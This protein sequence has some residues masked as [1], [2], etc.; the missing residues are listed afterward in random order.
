MRKVM[1]P[2]DVAHAWANQHQDEARNSGGSFYFNGS[3]IYSYG[4]HFPI[5]K[6]VTNEQGQSA[7]LFTTRTYSSTTSGHVSIAR[8]AA[9]HKNLIYCNNPEASD[10]SN[11]QSWIN[12]AE[13]VVGLLQ[14]ARKPEKYLQKL[15]EIEYL[16]TRYSEFVGVPIPDILKSV[17]A[18]KNSDE[19]IAYLASKSKL[20]AAQ[21]KKE[22]SDRLKQFNKTLKKWEKGEITSIYGRSPKNIDFLRMRSDGEEVQTSQGICIPKAVAKRFYD[23]IQSGEVEAGQEFLRF[24]IAQIDDKILKIGCH[25]YERQYITKFADKYLN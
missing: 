7:T 14:K 23:R 20:L 16:A 9:N 3:T 22:K 21:A 11:Y 12:D 8:M 1:S 10:A 5:A 2:Q 6:H 15:G 4:S 17:L 13:H 25:T 19:H 24:N 18:V